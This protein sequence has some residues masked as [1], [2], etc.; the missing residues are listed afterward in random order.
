MEHVRFGRT[1]LK[2][3]RL[4][5]GTMTFL[6]SRLHE[7]AQP[8][9]EGTRFTLDAAAQ[10]YQDCYWNDRAFDTVEQLQKVAA[11]AGLACRRWPSPGRWPTPW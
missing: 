6:R 10:R 1:G 2:V 3:S 4:C 8:P 9:P 11:D 5:L 7:R